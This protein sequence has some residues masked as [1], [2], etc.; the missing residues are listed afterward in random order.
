MQKFKIDRRETGLFSEQQL[1]LT[2]NQDTFLPFLENVFSLE[3]I[4]RQAS[5]KQ[6]WFSGEKRD[7]LQ[8]VFEEQYAKAERSQ[9]VSFNLNKLKESNT[10]T[11]TTGH[12]LSLFTGPVFFVYK[13]LHTIKLCELLSDKFKEHHFV[14]VFWL[15]S[16]DH[17][18]EEIREV[19][20]FGRKIRWETDQDGAVGRMTVE[21]LESLKSELRLLFKS[22]E[23]DEIDLLLSAYQGKNLAEATFNL[24]NKLFGKYGLLCLNADHKDLKRTFVSVL[25]KELLSKFSFDAVNLSTDKL[26][27]EGFKVQVKP[28]NINLF[29][30]NGLKRVKI[31]S[32]ETGFYIEDKGLLSEK[33]LLDMLHEHP[34]CFS[35][36]VVL[37]PLYQE[38]IL[39]NICYVGGVGEVSYWLQLK[40]VFD[41]VEVPFPLVQTRTSVLYI[42]SIIHKK[43]NKSGLLLEELFS[44]K[45]DLKRRKLKEQ[46]SE[47]LDFTDISAASDALSTE[48]MSKITSIDPGLEKYAGAEIAR[49]KNQI[50]AIQSRL[51]KVLK[52]KNEDQLLAIDAIYE[53]LFP[54]GMMQERVLNI[55]SM[56]PDG[57]ISE[58]IDKL[59]HAIDPLDPDL[60][61]LME[62]QK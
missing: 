3:T 59:Y 11:I 25:E 16:E 48:L 1:L 50:E 5:L 52:Q 45:E 26:K 17:D 49:I 30:I 55:F 28:N 43:M 6:K 34:E 58:R 40:G 46:A 4:E 27:Q 38:Y 53:R 7:L 8:R 15:A 32:E 44:D 54:D 20:V 21:G 14:P 60:L 22:N 35:P 31:L 41:A 56:C 13:I 36:N 33:Q 12:Q 39:P 51:I 62:V 18:L 24:V 23:L 37:R 19:D 47:E 42:D 61:I 29:Y 2:Y 9:N 57:K 10:Y